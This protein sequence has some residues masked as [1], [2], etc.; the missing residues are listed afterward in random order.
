MNEGD[1]SAVIYIIAHGKAD[2]FIELAKTIKDALLAMA[3]RAYSEDILVWM[4]K[5]TVV[6][7]YHVIIAH[8]FC[9][10][11]GNTWVKHITICCLLEAAT[12]RFALGGLGRPTSIK[13][14]KNYR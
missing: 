2:C 11:R 7:N 14:T 3:I 8:M 1:H 5:K 9:L 4:F 12:H 13:M 10:S 6:S